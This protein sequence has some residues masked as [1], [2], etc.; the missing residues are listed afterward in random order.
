VRYLYQPNR[1]VAAA[2]NTGIRA[3][4]GEFVALLDSDDIWFPWKIE[5]QLCCLERHSEVG[6]VWTDME[7]IDPACRVFNSS[8]LRTMY[9]AYQWFPQ[10]KLFPEWASLEDMVPSLKE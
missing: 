8:Y 10:D 6:M 1:G 5:L 4:S 3:A 9:S 7:A 2:R